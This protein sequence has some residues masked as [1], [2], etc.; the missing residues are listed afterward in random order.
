MFLN[1]YLSGFL[2]FQPKRFVFT[3]FFSGRFTK[4]GMDNSNRG[5]VDILKWIFIVVDIFV[6]R[7]N[8][9]CKECC[10]CPATAGTQRADTAASS[11][12][13]P[14][15]LVGAARTDTPYLWASTQPRS[16]HPEHTETCGCRGQICG[17]A[18]EPIRI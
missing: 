16:S 15:R 13:C 10:L 12:P 11:P 9:I 5:H 8:T 2:L 17:H 18:L 4:L 7:K 6:D 14:G 3:C 1:T